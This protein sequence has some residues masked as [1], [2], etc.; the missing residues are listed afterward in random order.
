[1]ISMTKDGVPIKC[2]VITDQQRIANLLKRTLKPEFIAELY[3]KVDKYEEIFF[4]MNCGIKDDYPEVMHVLVHLS[5][6]PEE[7]PAGSFITIFYIHIDHFDIAVKAAD[8]LKSHFQQMNE[9]GDKHYE[10]SGDSKDI[11]IL[12]IEDIPKN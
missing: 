1:M 8:A 6:I 2:E 11:T 10:Y 3:R 7:P 9:W 12:P 4:Q 5:R